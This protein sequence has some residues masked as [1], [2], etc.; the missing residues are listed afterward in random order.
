MTFLNIYLRFLN[1]ID[2]L[3]GEE[4]RFFEDNAVTLARLLTRW[5]FLARFIGE[6]AT[7]W[8]F[9]DKL[10]FRFTRRGAAR[11]P[12]RCPACW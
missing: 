10:A 11:S 7:R 6:L 5:A 8:T 2:F 1:N 3:E 12:A 4:V 9:I